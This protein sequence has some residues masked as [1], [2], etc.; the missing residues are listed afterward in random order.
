MAEI[1][2]NIAVTYTF[3]DA[4]NA[5]NKL[6]SIDRITD[7]LICFDNHDNIRSLQRALSSIDRI[8][9]LNKDTSDPYNVP[10]TTYRDICLNYTDL[11]YVH[12]TL[13]C[14]MSDCV[15]YMKRYRNAFC[16]NQNVKQDVEYILFNILIKQYDDQILG[17]KHDF[18]Q[19]IYQLSGLKQNFNLHDSILP[20]KQMYTLYMKYHDHLE[21][22]G[23]PNDRDM[24]KMYTL[25]M[26]YHDHLEHM[27]APKMF[28]Q[29]ADYMISILPLTQH[30]TDDIIYSKDRDFLNIYQEIMTQKL[31]E[32]DMIPAMM[33]MICDK[34]LQTENNN[35]PITM[36]D[37]MCQLILIL[38][39]LHV[40]SIYIQ[41]EI[42]QL[43]RYQ[44][45]RLLDL[46]E[47]NLMY[48][49]NICEIFPYYYEL[50]VELKML[51]VHRLIGSADK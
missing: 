13:I 43:I 44:S 24:K 27:G 46:I 4:V 25:Y 7:G 16:T 30:C 41:Y 20:N 18:I 19:H 28:I 45:D 8:D 5:L 42:D 47:Q 31:V 32:E 37:T 26:K 1:Y 10:N 21:H 15:K 14:A 17:L 48:K 3:N 29:N 33:D 38:K 34:I 51:I 6:L 39:N 2:R 9:K 49:A 12:Q 40:D 36:H 11:Y 22:M 23:T 50:P 35:R